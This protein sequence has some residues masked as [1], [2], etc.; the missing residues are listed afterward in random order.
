VHPGV[1]ARSV[2]GRSDSYAIEREGAL[3][4]TCDSWT[5]A[6]EVLEFTLTEA[7]LATCRRAVHLHAAGAVVRDGAILALGGSGTGK[8]SLALCWSAAG[9]PVLGDDV[10]LLERDGRVGPFRRLFK[11][12]SHAL[13]LLDI[14]PASTPFWEPDSE[15][16]WYDPTVDAGWAGAANV[17]VVAVCRPSPGSEPVVQPLSSADGVNALMHSVTETGV[18]AEAAIET[19]VSVSQSARIVE[20]RFDPASPVAAASLLARLAS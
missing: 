4:A 3:V 15:E 19:L 10:V 8:S 17:A 1:K 20:L 13:G 2:D 11:V 12:P 7:L 9:R 5:R 6:L 14:S 18:A 16:A